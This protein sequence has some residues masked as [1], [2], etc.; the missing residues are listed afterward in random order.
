MRKRPIGIAVLLTA[1][2]LI[3]GIF[4]ENR[5]GSN[6]VWRSFETVL[7][8]PG[9]LVVKAVGPGHGFFQLVLPFLFS[10]AFY[11]AMFW[12]IVVYLERLLGRKRNRL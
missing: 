1:L 10:L 4:A 3:F 6:R 9:S 8:F 5:L 2:L 11:I 12:V 7:N